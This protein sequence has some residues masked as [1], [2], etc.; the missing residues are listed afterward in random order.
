M[1]RVTMRKW[2]ALSILAA[3]SWPAMA[4]KSLSIEEFE[5]LL[6]KLQG[7]PDARV[8][9]DLAE[10][11]LAERVSPQRLAKW[12]KSFPGDKTREVL[13]RLSDMAAFQNHRR[14]KRSNTRWPLSRKAARAMR[15]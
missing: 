1:G 9:G 14:P 8:A 12:E 11:E 13:V 3:L 15:R 10:I 2:L 5:Q 7:K 4:A 6:N